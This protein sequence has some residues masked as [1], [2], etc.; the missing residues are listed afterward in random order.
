MAELSLGYCPKGRLMLQPDA[1]HWLQHE[2]PA[3]ISEAL[4]TFFAAQN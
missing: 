1:G 4:K 2:E 3:I